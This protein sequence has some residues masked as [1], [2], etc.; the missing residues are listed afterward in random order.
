ML[1]IAAGKTFPTMLQSLQILGVDPAFVSQSVG[2]TLRSWWTAGDMTDAEEEPFLLPERTHS[3]LKD[4]S[5]FLS[6]NKTV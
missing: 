3:P 6:V 2:D 4:S 5:W 1:E